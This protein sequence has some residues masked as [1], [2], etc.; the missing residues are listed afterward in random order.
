MSQN[1]KLNFLLIVVMIITTFSFAFS[2]NAAVSRAVTEAA[3]NDFK[4]LQEKN[5]DIVGVLKSKKD[6]SEWAEVIEQYEETI[7]IFDKDS[8]VIFRKGN[9]TAL[10]VKVRTSF[11]YKGETYLLRSSV[12]LLRDYVGDSRGVIRFISVELLIGIT[13]LFIFI[14]I[15]YNAMLKPFRV[16]YRAIEE[17]DRSGKLLDIR[18]KGYAGKVYKRF[19]SMAKNLDGQQMDQR[20]IIASISHDIKTPLTSIMGYSEQLKK[21]NLS[22]ERRER[23]I[24]T[25]YEKAVDIRTI[26][27]EFDEYLGYKLSYEMKKRKY[28]VSELEKVLIN[29][30][31]DDFSLAGIDFRVN[32][33]TDSETQLNCDLQKLK[34][35]YGNII[36]NS[37]KHS[38]SQEKK[39]RITISETKDSVFFVFADNGEGVPEDKLEMIFEPLYTSDEGRR[40]AGLGLSICRGIVE[41]HDGTIYA[42][43]SELGGLAVCIELPK[44]WNYDDT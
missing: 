42:E 17:Y 6:I 39:I 12:Y 36:T 35:V 25:V 32:N 30:Y 10:D 23:Y 15:I 7:Y 14:C 2:Y 18:P 13:A 4:I 28:L 19:A 38:G 9:S 24:N 3:S 34:R 44:G 27:S 8:N 16:V 22:E 26:L 21:N 33:F 37:I 41:A 31:A 43:K 29:D 5:M 11:E 40:V 20:R 1:R